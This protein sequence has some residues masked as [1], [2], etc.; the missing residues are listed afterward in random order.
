ML[1][2]RSKTICSNSKT[3]GDKKEE[4]RTNYDLKKTDRRKH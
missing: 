2:E 3:S 4:K 1:A